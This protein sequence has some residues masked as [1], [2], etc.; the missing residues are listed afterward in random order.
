[1]LSRE[2]LQG[3]LLAAS[4]PEL[5]IYRNEKKNLG[6]EVRARVFFRADSSAFLEYVQG[7]LEEENIESQYR[8]AESKVRPKPV[9]WVSGITNLVRLASLVPNYPDSKI[10][11]D[12]FKL[13]LDTIYEG[14]HNTQVGLD[15]LL[16]LK[17]LL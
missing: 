5:T 13:A 6:Y 3:I 17:G 14:E 2:Q 12:Y 7:A 10:Q 1:V 8:L 11:W 4:R 9:L 16:K 15:K